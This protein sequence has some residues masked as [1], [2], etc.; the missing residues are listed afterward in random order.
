MDIVKYIKTLLKFILNLIIGKLKSHMILK[1]KGLLKK[2]IEIIK[3]NKIKIWFKNKII[4]ILMIKT[5][6]TI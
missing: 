5:I 3:I 2:E 1:S 4:V 6:K